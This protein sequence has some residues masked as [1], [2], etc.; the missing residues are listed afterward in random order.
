MNKNLV[1]KIL[2]K[3]THHFLTI[4]VITL[5][6]SL[7][8]INFMFSYLANQ[9]Q[10]INKDYLTNNNVKVIHVNG[11]T[12]EGSSMEAEVKDKELINRLFAENGLSGKAKAYPI[13]ILPSVF[14]SSLDTGIS[15][16]GLSEELSFLISDN[17]TLKDNSICVNKSSNEEINLKIPVI[18]EMDG[19]FSSNETVD[20]K[21]PTEQGAKNE[22]AIQIHSIPSNNQ[23]YINEKEAQKLLKIMFKNSANSFEYIQESHLDKVIVYVKDIKDV[24]TVGELLKKHQYFTSYTFNSFENFSANISSMQVILIVLSIIFIITSI[25]IAVLLMINFLRLQRKEI[26]ILKLNGYNNKSISSIYARLISIML[27][28]VFLVSLLFYLINYVLKFIPVSYTFLLMIVGIDFVILLLSIA[29]IYFFGIKKICN[30]DTM[31]LLKKGK[32]FE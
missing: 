20:V 30:L 10:M 12:E 1:V 15:I 21:F 11:K 23:A 27:G 5:I 32:E 19:G 3:K 14:N 29:F 28:R 16:I 25:I 17:C 31:E 7:T 9:Y 24:D 6:V 4:S 2:R 22:N 18:E 13:Y 8:M 26:A